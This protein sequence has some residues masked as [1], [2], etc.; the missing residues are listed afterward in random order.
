MKK[1]FRILGSFILTLVAVLTLVACSNDEKYSTAM[2]NV[3]LLIDDIWSK[4]ERL[5]DNNNSLG[6]YITSGFEVP[7]ETKVD[8]EVIA[9]NYSISGNGASIAKNDDTKTTEVAVTQTGEVQKFVL[10]VSIEKVDSKSWEFNVDA[11]DLSMEKTQAEIDA[12]EGLMTYSEYAAAESGDSILIQGWITHPHD[13]SSSYGNAS[14]WLQDEDGGYYAYRVNV[15]SQR[16]WDTYFKVGNKIAIKGKLSPYNGWN[17]IGQGCSYYYIKD[18]ETKTFTAKD[19]TDIWGANAPTSDASKAVQNQKVTVTAKVASLP[20]YNSEDMTMGITVN[21]QT[22]YSVYFKDAYVGSIKEGLLSDLQIGYTIQ[23]EGLV[24]V[25][26]SG[27]QICPIT[28]DGCYTITSTEVTDQDRVEATKTQVKNIG[29]A[30]AYYSNAE[31]E[32][33]T[34]YSASGKDVA[35]AYS[36]KDVKGTGIAVVDN[37]LVI[38]ANGLDAASA[39]LV[40]AITCGE[41]TGTQEISIVVKT[42]KDVLE[43]LTTQYEKDYAANIPSAF[44]AGTVNQIKDLPSTAKQGATITYEISANDYLEI[45]TKESSKTQYLRVKKDPDLDTPLIVTI[46][47]TIKYDNPALETEVLTQTVAKEV[48]I[49]KEAASQLQNF[50]LFTSHDDEIE[51]EAYIAYKGEFSGGN[52]NNFCVYLADDEGGYYAYRLKG[53]Q[54]TYDALNVGDF[55]KVTGTKSDND[56]GIQINSGASFEE[57]SKPSYEYSAEAISMTEENLKDEDWFK[58]HTADYV[59]LT[60]EIVKLS[61]YSGKSGTLAT[62]KIGET[63][64]AVAI[65]TYLWNDSHGAGAMAVVN[66]VKNSIVGKNVTISGYLA[67]YKGEKQ[68]NIVSADGFVSEAL[69]DAEKIDLELNNVASLF[70]SL[71][72]EADT[73]ALPATGSSYADVQLTWSLDGSYTSVVL[74][75][76]NLTITPSQTLEEVKV[77]VV[78]KLGEVQKEKIISFSVQ[79]PEIGDVTLKYTGSKTTNMDGTNQATLLGA[80]DTKLSVVGAKGTKNIFPGLGSNGSIRL[81]GNAKDG[82]SLTISTLDGKK[83]AKIVLNYHSASK[84]GIFTITGLQDTVTAEAGSSLTVE[85]AEG[86]TEIVIH[87]VTDGSTQV[88]FASIEIFYAE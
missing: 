46:T 18:A 26:K 31:I 40:A 78:A 29:F 1:S 56:Y 45:R 13:Y 43:E 37:K 64:L 19:I 58:L 12:M 5:D 75:D 84:A 3:S 23:I 55:V 79:L 41:A 24:S 76:N 10:T 83:I 73:V 65:N 52:Y 20:D 38:E 14:V 57:I 25:T 72:K 21:G 32:L 8:G 47:A 59:T 62:V 63:E 39:T 66:A 87:N 36:L 69:T 2:N 11:I 22:G 9:V 17:E 51:I 53:T 61:D 68:I 50:Y 15:K 42:D 85:Y 80:D 33:L 44:L 88:H 71:Y 81:Y 77:K 27:A 54:E 4:N 28:Q 16:E 67:Q 48:A 7:Y 86:V 49:M 60:G 35:I 6:A 34:S 74:A 30:D 82:N 70:D